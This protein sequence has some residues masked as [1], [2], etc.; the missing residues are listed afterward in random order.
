MTDTGIGISPKV[1]TRLF[2]PFSQADVSMTR[3]FGGTGLGLAICKRLVEQM[4][5][6]IGLDSEL[7]RGSTFW[8]TVR[9]Q[10]PPASDGLEDTR[11]PATLVQAAS[12]RVLVVDDN[13]TNRTILREQLVPVGLL[14]TSV[15]DGP[16]GLE[17]LRRAV[18]RG[19]PFAVAILDRHMPGMDGLTL[20]REISADPTLANMPMVLLTSLGE[21]DRRDVQAAG[22]QHV[23]T[24][25]VRQSQLLAM[26]STLL[27]VPLG[28]AVRVPSPPTTGTSRRARQRAAS[29]SL[30]AEN[31]GGRGHDHQ[32]A[33]GAAH[34]GAARLPRRRGQQRRRGARRAGE[35]S[36]RAGVDGRADARN[37]RLRSDRADPTTRSSSPDTTRRS[38]P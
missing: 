8:F 4:G 21:E 35:H 15:G 6:E 38:W 28:G 25:P 31:P 37:G 33:R 19:E 17:V 32:S 18:R 3:E 36:V 9:L 14:V 24:K 16:A 29:A 22:F 34:A 7:G 27:G 20:A 30:R 12:L 5:G 10:R 26:L 2:Q 11:P 23:L 1:A 13:D